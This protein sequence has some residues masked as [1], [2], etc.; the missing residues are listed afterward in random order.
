VGLAFLDADFTIH[1]PSGFR[2]ACQ[3]FGARL[4]NSE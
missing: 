3:A 2:A 4:M 1:E